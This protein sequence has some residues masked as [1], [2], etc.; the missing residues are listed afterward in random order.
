MWIQTS[1][2][3]AIAWSNRALVISSIGELKQ[4]STGLGRFGSSVNSNETLGDNSTTMRGETSRSLEFI[5]IK[6]I[7][8]LI[9]SV[10]YF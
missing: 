4:L 7:S 3:I 8:S 5:T 10:A 6:L 1:N 9:S 2:S